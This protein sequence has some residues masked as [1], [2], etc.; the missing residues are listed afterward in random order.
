VHALKTTLAIL[1]DLKQL[2]DI[3][4]YHH[5]TIEEEVGQGI[6]THD[7][8][9]IAFPSGRS[10]RLES[11]SSGDQ[12]NTSLFV[13][14]VSAMPPIIPSPESKT[15]IKQS[16]LDS[17]HELPIEEAKQQCQVVGHVAYVVDPNARAIP[18]LARPNTVV[19]WNDG[20]KVIRAIAGDGLE[21]SPD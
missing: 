19:L 10:L 20:Q 17:L 7:Q 16:F 12:E 18:L 1:E 11:C 2:G 8:L 9:D 14:S 13:C 21:L 5:Q 6:Q 3:T 15:M 4:S